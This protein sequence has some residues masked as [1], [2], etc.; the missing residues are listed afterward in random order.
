VD[1]GARVS[2]VSV[3]YPMPGRIES[4]AFP[5]DQGTS[6]KPGVQGD[7]FDVNVNMAQDAWGELMEW[8]QTRDLIFHN[9][10][11][12]LQI[13]NRGHRTFGHGVDL[14]P[15]IAQW[16]LDPQHS[17]SLKPTSARLWG[18][19]ERAEQAALQPIL[20]SNGNRFDL[21]PWEL[22]KPYAAKDA[23]LTLR[24]YRHQ[25]LVL[26]EDNYQL[27]EE[28]DRE[29]AVTS[30][31]TKM[32]YRGIGY[33]VE[34]SK[35]EAARATQALMTLQQALPFKSTTAGARKYFFGTLGALPHCSTEKSGP[36][37]AECCIRSLIA[38]HVPHAR[39]YADYSKY[40]HAIGKY[41]TG[42]AEA[43]GEDGR[44]RTD[45]RQAG[46]TTMRFTSSRVNL[47]A[48]PHDYKLERLEGIATPRSLFKPA[49]GHQLWEFDLAQAECRAAA[50]VADCQPW[51]SM[52]RS[53]HPRDL[54]GET[55]MQL[56]GDITHEHRQI[57]KRA[58]FSLIYG[59]GP[60][61]F[62]KDTE[63]TS[64]VQLSEADAIAIVKDWRKLYPE[65]GRAGRKYERVAKA[66]TYV[67]LLGGRRRYFTPYDELHKAFNAVIQGSIAQFVKRWMV[68]VE[69]RFGGVVL[70][71][72]DSVVVE[73]PTDKV[74][75]WTNDITDLGS[76]LATEFFDVPMLA[77][78]KQWKTRA[79]LAN[80]TSDTVG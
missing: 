47:Q 26:E 40:L 54:H 45:F 56:F 53:E 14:L 63:K 12:D 62:R 60:T 8:L 70:Q 64:G 43:T 80:K 50:V 10:Y 67:T 2:V 42:Y 6:D 65:F 52:F 76:E 24:L 28:L 72:H 49:D 78:A 36:S 7:L 31:L 30:V 35:I 59:V 1:D 41:Y 11:F 74:G 68:E 18:E 23:E 66:Q 61:T 3:A 55:A 39:E 9:A 25:L 44:L 33:D 73:I 34:Q 4:T 37:V 46:T 5:F 20:K 48:I 13:I 19:D 21:L 58:N 69:Y 22:I 32:G 57:A 38:Q 71:I 15:Q 51:L 16:V 29:F 17:T 75:R 79:D 27:E 77:E